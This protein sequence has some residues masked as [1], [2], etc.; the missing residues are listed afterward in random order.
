MSSNIKFIL[1]VDDDSDDREF[2]SDAFKEVN[3]GI[4]L[5]MAEHGLKALDYLY[6]LK[7]GNAEL[8][9]LIILD[10]NMPYLNGMETFDKLKTDVS[11]QHIPVVIFTSSL[12]PKDKLLFNNLGVEFINKPNSIAEMRR[13]AN[14]MIL[15][16]A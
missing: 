12:H 11:L 10:I 16:C 7:E 8:P 2:L 5:V 14:Q 3:Q 4:K 6:A 13:I 1:Y 9:S 15:E